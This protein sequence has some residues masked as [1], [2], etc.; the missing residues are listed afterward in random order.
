MA[1][2]DGKQLFYTGSKLCKIM[3]KIFG[4]LQL[5]YYYFLLINAT[6]LNDKS[7]YV[8]RVCAN[9]S[10]IKRKKNYLLSKIFFWTQGHI[11][12]ICFLIL[13]YVHF[14]NASK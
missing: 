4:I 3:F 11:K 9:Y 13:K 8:L 6:L 5:L 12:L 7:M 1:W 10:V 14:N 2:E